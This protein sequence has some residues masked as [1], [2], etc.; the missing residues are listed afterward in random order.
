MAE[1]TEVAKSIAGP[2]ARIRRHL[3]SPLYEV[4]TEPSSF[5]KLYSTGKEA[6]RYVSRALLA[7]GLFMQPLSEGANSAAAGEPVRPPTK[8]VAEFEAEHVPGS[9]YARS[10]LILTELDGDTPLFGDVARVFHDNLDDGTERTN[11]GIRLPINSAITGQLSLYEIEHGDYEGAGARLR[12]KIGNWILSGVAERAELDGED[13]SLLGAGIGKEFKWH[14]GKTALELWGYKKDG[15]GFPGIF[16]FHWF[17][18]GYMGGLS[19]TPDDKAENDLTVSFGRSAP[20]DSWL[21]RAGGSPD[22]GRF[23]AGALYAYG[24]RLD[25]RFAP[26]PYGYLNPDFG[27]ISKTL[28]SNALAYY[29]TIKIWERGPLALGCNYIRSGAVER[30]NFQAALSPLDLL[31]EAVPLR[32]YFDV[33]YDMDLSCDSDVL[34]GGAGFRWRGLDFYVGKTEGRDPLFFV[35][36]ISSP[37]SIAR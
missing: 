12:G 25:R 26:T 2:K 19:F 34:S 29:P 32:P 18:S 22:G 1:I 17:D 30:A 28:W 6:V 7:A 3:F 31:E 11:A 10:A 35:Q 33:G 9:D 13:A 8:Y 37:F 27:I 16:A 15:N 21:V 4:T 20:R 36:L 14:A 5:D 24:P 23:C